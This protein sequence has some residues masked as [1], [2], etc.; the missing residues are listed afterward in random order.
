MATRKNRNPPITAADQKRLAR[1]LKMTALTTPLL[2]QTSGS[3]LAMPKGV[4][5]SRLPKRR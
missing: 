2:R 1:K 5:L 4:R 3:H